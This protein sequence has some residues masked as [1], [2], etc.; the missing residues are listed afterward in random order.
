MNY[1]VGT[2]LDSTAKYWE[3]GDVDLDWGVSPGSQCWDYSSGTHSPVKRYRTH[4]KFGCPIPHLSCADLNKGQGINV[5]DPAMV[6]TV[7]ILVVCEVL[8]VPLNSCRD[9]MSQV[10]HAR[11]YF[12]HGYYLSSLSSKFQHGHVAMPWTKFEVIWHPGI[13]HSQD[14]HSIEFECR[15]KINNETTSNNHWEMAA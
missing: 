11:N 1:S 9:K 14:K 2:W 12:A 8:P 15:A 10:S 5:E 7:T 13:E 3:L 4:S 6:T